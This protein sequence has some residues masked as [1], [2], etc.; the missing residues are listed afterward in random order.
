MSFNFHEP[1]FPHMLMKLT[2][3]RVLSLYGNQIK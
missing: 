3:K 2:T 1:Q